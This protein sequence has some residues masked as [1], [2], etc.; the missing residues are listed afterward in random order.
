MPPETPL[1][2][3]ALLRYLRKRFS[4]D[5]HGD[6]GGA[7]WARVKNNGLLLAETT[8]AN[9]AVVEL[10]AFF[11]DSCRENEYEDEDHG[12]RGAELAI[13]LRGNIFDAS[14]V[15]MDLLVDACAGHSDGRIE[16]DITVQTCWDADRL[17]LGRVGFYPNPKKLC[18]AAARV[19]STIKRAYE[20][21]IRQSRLLD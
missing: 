21:S 16:A 5:W 17:D 11:H 6:H 12:K 8:G 3:A 10:F 2:S 15:E 18:T 1:N 7:H 19:P 20:R 13:T 4:I 9:I 14:D